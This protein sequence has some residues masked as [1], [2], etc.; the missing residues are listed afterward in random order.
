MAENEDN[1]LLEK[2]KTFF[3]QYKWVIP[4]VLVIIVVMAIVMP[5]MGS[6][7]SLVSKDVRVEQA[8]GNVQSALERRAD[9]I[10]NLVAT[11]EGSATFEQ[12]TLV[13]VIEARASATQIKA[14][15]ESAETA[16][17]LQA[18]QDS[19]AGVIGRLLLVYEQYPQLQ[20]TVAFREL[21]AQL[22]AT[23]N[24]INS[25]RNNYNTAVLDY[26]T[27]VRSFPSNIIARWFG[28]EEDKWSMFQVYPGKSEVPV[29]QFNL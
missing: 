12:D 20:T 19:L 18:S 23:E 7:N 17:Q 9:L 24:Q 2:P 1:K 28:F 16:E 22:T 29:V 6:Y 8:R 5:I 15:I 3:E 11:I 14:Q 4:F 21:Q 26:K 25:E 13:K 10:P 27:T